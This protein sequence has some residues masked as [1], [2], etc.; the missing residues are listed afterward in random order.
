MRDAG[1]TIGCSTLL[2]AILAFFAAPGIQ[3]R[4]ARPLHFS[5]VEFRP[6]LVIIVIGAAIGAFI[7]WQ[8]ARHKKW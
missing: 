8:N 1:L 5:A 4:F 7:G 2:G 3:R 6:A